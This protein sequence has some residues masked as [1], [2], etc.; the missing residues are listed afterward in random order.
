MFS[1][2]DYLR[3]L[4]PCKIEHNKFVGVLLSSRQFLLLLCFV[5]FFFLIFFV[6]SSNI[7]SFLCQLLGV[8][9]FLFA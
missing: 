1:I 9:L 8:S 6:H 5:V 3:L 2:F 4:A 7:Y